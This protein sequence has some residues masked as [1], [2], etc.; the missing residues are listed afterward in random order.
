MLIVYFNDVNGFFFILH[1]FRVEDIYLKEKK[2]IH[3][4]FYK[5]NGIGLCLFEDSI[6]P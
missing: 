1:K 5:I 3:F 6:I 4:N 2:I